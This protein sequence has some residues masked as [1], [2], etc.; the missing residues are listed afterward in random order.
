[1]SF[2]LDQSD[3]TLKP[4]I[5]MDM[6]PAPWGTQAGYSSQTRTILGPGGLAIGVAVGPNARGDATAMSAVHE[7][8]DACRYCLDV[9]SQQ[10]QTSDNKGLETLADRLTGIGGA[11]A[12]ELL[13][14]ALNKSKGV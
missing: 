10:V 9:L 2:S 11:R 12:R 3:A 1:M 13:T 7:L 5:S 4:R 6:T 14:I 8:Q